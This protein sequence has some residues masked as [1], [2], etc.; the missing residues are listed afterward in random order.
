MCL[1]SATDAGGPGID[2][3]DE[4]EDVVESGGREEDGGNG[5]S[6]SEAESVMNGVPMRGGT[7]LFGMSMESGASA[8]WSIKCRF[9]DGT[10]NG[11]GRP[12]ELA[13]SS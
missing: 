11:V 13:E 3:T 10:S 12:S 5:Y 4:E 1:S 8:E 2:V 9:L 7:V 6:N